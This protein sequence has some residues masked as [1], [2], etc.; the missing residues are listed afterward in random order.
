MF[1]YEKCLVLWTKP[2]AREMRVLKFLVSYHNRNGKM[3]PS[4]REIGEAC[5]LTSTSVVNFY[6]DNLEKIKMIQR[7]PKISRG[8]LITPAGYSRATGISIEELKFCPH[9]GSPLS[10]T[11]SVVI[12][13]EKIIA[14]GVATMK[15]R[16]RIDPRKRSVPAS[17]AG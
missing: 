6:L 10:D 5:N 17:V 13:D 3:M 16:V 7:I 8:L 4:I 11:A 9:C 2:E 12:T 14:P 15:A 1:E